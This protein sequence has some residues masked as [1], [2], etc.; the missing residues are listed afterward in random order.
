M[1]FYV[2]VKFMCFGSHDFMQQ[3]VVMKMDAKNIH[4][5]AWHRARATALKQNKSPLEAK[6][7]GEFHII[8]VL[9]A[10]GLNFSCWCLYMFYLCSNS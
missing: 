6:A 10:F 3:K 2:T 5:R 8:I 7:L 9:Q 4:S 1:Y